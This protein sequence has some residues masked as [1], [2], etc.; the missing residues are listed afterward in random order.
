MKKKCF[1]YNSN[2]AWG[3]GLLY[4]PE[5]NHN[6]VAKQI[7][8]ELG[9][10]YLGECLGCFEFEEAFLTECIDENTVT[11]DGVLFTYYDDTWCI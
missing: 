1:V 4:I 11:I 7:V 9:Q 8:K 10:K 2:Q 6:N 3:G 5:E